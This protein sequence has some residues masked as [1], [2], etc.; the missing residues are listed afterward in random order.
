MLDAVE[1]IFSL[2]FDLQVVLLEGGASFCS[3]IS[4]GELGFLEYA[5][6]ITSGYK[7]HLLYKT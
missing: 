4:L 2:G 5:H 7:L 6:S 3:V 1:H